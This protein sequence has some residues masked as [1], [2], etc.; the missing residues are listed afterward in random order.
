M[1]L[2]DLMDRR[3]VPEHVERVLER[4]NVEYRSA[5]L[6]DP[7]AVSSADGDINEIYHFAAIIGVDNVLKVPDRVL[8]TNAVTTLN[9]FNYASTLKG[10]RRL[11]FSSTSEVYAGTLKHFGIPLPTPENVPLCVDDISAPRTSYALSKIYGEAIAFAWRRT[12]CVP[13]TIVRYH[14]IYG[15]HMG[16]RHVI[17]QTFIKI[18]QSGGVVEVPSVH[19]TRAFCFI[20]DA[21]EATIRCVREQKTEG[22]VIHVGDSRE[23]ITIR[24]LVL[25][26]GQVMGRQIM[27]KEMQE[28]EGSPARRCPDTTALEQLTGFRAHVSLDEGLRRTYEWCKDRM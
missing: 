2:I 11:L 1:L 22:K 18:A 7:N 14:N 10:L 23:E 26:I 4:P 9:I 17:P 6:R 25:R 19:H 8:E 5:E 16:F 28:T 15:P 20:D 3:R 21:V 13:V 24:D 27:V 12:R